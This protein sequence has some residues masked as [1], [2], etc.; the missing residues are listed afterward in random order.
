MTDYTL[1]CEQPTIKCRFILTQHQEFQ[2]YVE[3]TIPEVDQVKKGNYD[4][5]DLWVAKNP[6]EDKY[7]GLCIEKD[8]VSKIQISGKEDWLTIKN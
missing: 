6:D 8:T 4:I 7:A 1:K 2:L 5:Y 3:L